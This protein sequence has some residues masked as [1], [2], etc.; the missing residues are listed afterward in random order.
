[1]LDDNHKLQNVQVIISETRRADETLQTV[2][3][4]DESGVFMTTEEA[5]QSLSRADSSGK[6]S[7]LEEEALEGRLNGDEEWRSRLEGMEMHLE[8]FRPGDKDADPFARAEELAQFQLDLQHE[9][10]K[11]RRSGPWLASENERAKLLSSSWSCKLVLDK[12]QR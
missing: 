4:I 2:F 8:E 3:L 1:M 10:R 6:I 11:L 12:L 7:A 5:V 9:R